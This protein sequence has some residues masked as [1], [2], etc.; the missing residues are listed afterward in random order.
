MT[1]D[2]R[3]QHEEKQKASNE[4]RL[5]KAKEFQAQQQ[6]KLAAPLTAKERKDIIAALESGRPANVTGTLMMLT[7][8]EP[9]KDDKDV[10][11]AIQKLLSDSNGGIRRNASEAWAKW[12]ALLVEDS[13]KP[14]ASG[15]DKRKVRPK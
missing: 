9:T 8:R 7:K 10:A 15:T 1:D 6:A 14:A 11:K 12:S 13:D 2:E 4:E 3:K 5:A